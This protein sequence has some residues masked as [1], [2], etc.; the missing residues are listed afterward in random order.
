M[1]HGEIFSSISTYFHLRQ[2]LVMVAWGTSR[3]IH[4]V[5]W[6]V[7]FG[8][9]D[10][11]MRKRARRGTQKRHSRGAP[12]CTIHNSLLL[13]CNHGAGTGAPRLYVLVVGH[14]FLL[15]P[16]YRCAME[17]SIS[18]PA[19]PFF[20]FFLT[21]YCHC[22][23]IDGA[24]GQPRSPVAIGCGTDWQNKGSGKRQREVVGC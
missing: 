4:V 16:G 3:E 2:S 15:R 24:L 12:P 1:L 18:S 13:F 9:I 19:I 6:E 11:T 21:S 17:M 20:L 10:L 7:E 23:I 5:R 8:E 22:C 14:M